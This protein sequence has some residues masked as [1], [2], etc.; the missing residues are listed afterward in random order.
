[1]TDTAISQIRRKQYTGKVSEYT[2]DV[3]L[4]GINYDCESKKHTCQIEKM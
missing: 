4:V 3:L 1:M 2:G